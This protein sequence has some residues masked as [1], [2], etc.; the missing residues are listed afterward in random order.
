MS[1]RALARRAVAPL[2]V[3]ALFVAGGAA[4]AGAQAPP[5]PPPTNPLEQLLRGILA[6]TTTVP[7][8]PGTPAPP[9]GAPGAPRPGPPAP[10]APP[11]TV[12]PGARTV[13]P[14]AQAVMNSIRRTG[15]NSSRELMNDLRLLVDVGLSPAE[16][17][18][19]GMGHFPVAGEAAFSD[20]FYF[21]R[22]TPSFHLHQGNDI[23]AARGVPVRAPFDG[24]LRFTEGGSAGKSAYVTTSDG[25]YYFMCHLDSFARIPSGS[26]VK[27]GDIVGTNGDTGNAKGGSPHVH[28][29]IHPKG[30]AAVNPKPFLDRW[31]A[32]ARANIPNIL[33]QYQVGLPRALTS[34]GVLRRFDEQLSVVSEADL[35]LS[36][37]SNPSGVLR[38][39]EIRAARGQAARGQR[40]QAAL[41]EAWRAANETGR[42]VLAPVTPALLHNVLVPDP[43]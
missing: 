24:T 20:D 35:F 30:G 2:V 36:Q 43:T 3:A 22:F 14:D 40:S 7:R 8:P 15:G 10:P 5:T 6:P 28:F 4:G 39:S 26:R 16:A 13:P 33:A 23:F 9:P 1:T 42:A 21:P 18:Q 34:A 29:E 32:E 17:A 25:T 27:Q 19:I 11:T 31:L 41:E 37:G 12:A 38:L